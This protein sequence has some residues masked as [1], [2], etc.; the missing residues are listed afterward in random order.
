MTNEEKLISALTDISEGHYPMSTVFCP[1]DKD[2]YVRVEMRVK[3]FTESDALIEKYVS[4][5]PLSEREIAA[6]QKWLSDNG[7]KTE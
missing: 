6:A 1:I 4:K 3:S 5:E 2:R 7:Y